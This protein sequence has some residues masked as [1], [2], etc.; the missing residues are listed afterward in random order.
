M[1]T[2]EIQLKKFKK[3]SEQTII[4]TDRQRC[5]K[6]SDCVFVDVNGISELSQQNNYLRIS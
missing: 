2:N 6:L 5:S 1:E 3:Q 4:F